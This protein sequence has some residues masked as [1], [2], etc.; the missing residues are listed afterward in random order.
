MIWMHYTL[1]FIAAAALVA[2]F[3]FAVGYAFWCGSLIVIQLGHQIER[4]LRK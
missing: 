2:Q 3:D 4:S 1:A